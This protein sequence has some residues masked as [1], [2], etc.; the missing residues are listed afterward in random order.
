MNI[1]MIV[2]KNEKHNHKVI[3]KYI[4]TMSLLLR[5]LCFSFII[6]GLPSFNKI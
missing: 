3:Y 1:G 4:T 6:I 5:S 2:I